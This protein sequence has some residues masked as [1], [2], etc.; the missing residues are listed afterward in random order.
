M[1]QEWAFHFMSNVV[2]KF[3]DEQKKRIVNQLRD[4]LT[5]E[6]IGVIEIETDDGNTIG[7]RSDS[8]VVWAK[9]RNAVPPPQPAPQIV[10][11][12]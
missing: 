8:I 4:L 6:T 2:I 10:R 1:E 9:I 3:S 12:G 5:Q 11:A 7:F